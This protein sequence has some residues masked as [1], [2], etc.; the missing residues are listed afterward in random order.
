MVDTNNYTNTLA[1][2]FVS[3]YFNITEGSARR[4]ASS[5]STS[6]STSASSTAI[7]APPTSAYSYPASSGLTSE[8]RW[9]IGL[10]VGLGCTFLIYMAII[11]WY[12]RR[13]LANMTP[14]SNVPPPWTTMSHN[15][16]PTQDVAAQYSKLTVPVEVP[17]S[18]PRTP[19]EAPSDP[20]TESQL[21]HQRF[22][23]E[24]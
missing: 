1:N 23:L 7:V 13:R 14:G 11:M 20:R 3:G 18:K 10:G 19:V 4:K 9:G 15:P 8:A 24:S 22:E 21:Q 17:G 12:I 5:T 6:T 16:V 2:Y